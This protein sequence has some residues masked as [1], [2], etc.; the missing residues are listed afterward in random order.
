MSAGGGDGHSGNEKRTRSEEGKHK[1][2]EGDR[3]EC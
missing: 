1:R 2:R 3:G